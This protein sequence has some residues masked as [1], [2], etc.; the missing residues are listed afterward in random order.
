MGLFEWVR[1]ARRDQGRRAMIRALETAGV[2][3]TALGLCLSG[4]ES[5]RIF[6]ISNGELDCAD[7]IA[8]QA[9]DRDLV[10]QFNGCRHFDSFQGSAAE[11][12]YFLHVRPVG[13]RIIGG[14]VLARRIGRNDLQRGS[15]SRSPA[16]AAASSAPMRSRGQMTS[17][18]R[19]WITMR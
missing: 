13:G 3:P 17:A 9:S 5:R 15:P 7:R 4:A 10:V 19:C 16:T 11:L 18:F 12:I 6:V 8:R 1:R 2:V 14:D